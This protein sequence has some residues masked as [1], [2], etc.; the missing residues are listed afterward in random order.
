ME[1]TCIGRY[2]PYPKPGGACTCYLLTHAGKN[3]VLDM[4]CGALP[5]LLGVI[6]PE[7]IDALFLSHLHSDHISDALTLRYALE[8]CRKY[9][10]KET[11][12]PVFLPDSPQAEAGILA[13][14]PMIDAHF[15]SDGMACDICG[16]SA[17]FALMPHAVPSFAISLEAQGRRLVYSG[18]TRDGERLIPFAK[19]ADLLLM[20]AAV[21]S[22]HKISGVQH[23][24]AAQAGQIAAAANVRKMIVTHIF[25]KYNE[26]DIISEVRAGFADAQLAQELCTVEV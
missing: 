8:V 7:Q 11:P 3:I 2:G 1:L 12:L 4:G 24:S 19:H 21:L 23:V 14:H 9:G 18:D 22:M 15:L 25:P 26:N 5:K 13:S 10:I 16:L 17:R 20:E 6:E